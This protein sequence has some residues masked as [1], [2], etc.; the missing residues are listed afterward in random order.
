MNQERLRAMFED[1][2]TDEPTN[3]GL[4][5]DDVARGR[6][7]R[8]RRMRRRVGGAGAGAAALVAAALV[9]PASPLSLIDDERDG[10]PDSVQ[11]AATSPGGAPL[12]PEVAESPLLREIWAAVETELPDD[13]ELVDDSYVYDSGFGANGIYLSL[14]RHERW[15]TLTISVGNGRPDLEDFRPCSDAPADSIFWSNA[16]TCDEGH[17]HAG[18]WRLMSESDGPVQRLTVL[19]DQ[20]AAATVSLDQTSSD[21][22]EDGTALGPVEWNLSTEETDAIAAAAWAVGERHDPADL[23]S[24]IDLSE[25]L[26]AW[27]EMQATLEE[28]LDLGPLTPVAPSDEAS[29][30]GTYDPETGAVADVDEQWQTGT[31]AARYATEDGIEVDVMVWQV[32]RM[33]EPFCHERIGGC[34]LFSWGSDVAG[35]DDLDGLVGPGASGALGDRAGIHVVIGTGELVDPENPESAELERKVSAAHVALSRLVPFLGDDP[36]PISEDT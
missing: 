26:A 7:L 25:A 22:A 30:E 10:S 13:V 32:A 9:V 3:T 1:A 33:Y 5:D 31:I 12:S 21:I 6:A 36:S 27:P 8:G 29:V 14:E 11:P 34:H 16:H 17:D 20:S 19:E 24:G 2:L 15:F 28:R 23:T 18:R 35:Q 4:V